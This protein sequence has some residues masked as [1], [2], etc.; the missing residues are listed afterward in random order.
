MRIGTRILL[1]LAII[2]VSTLEWEALRT[3]APGK[4]YPQGK[5]EG[6][7]LLNSYRYYHAF[8]DTPKKGLNTGDL[9]SLGTTLRRHTTALQLILMLVRSRIHK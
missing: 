5:D 2:L 8:R 7:H 1:I 4:S 3:L 6:Y 9:I